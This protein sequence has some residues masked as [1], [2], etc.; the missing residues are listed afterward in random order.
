MK[1][2][3][4]VSYTRVY[5]FAK[6]ATKEIVQNR[7]ANVHQITELL[8]NYLKKMAL[9]AYIEGYNTSLEETRSKLS[10][11]NHNIGNLMDI[12]AKHNDDKP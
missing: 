2:E 9:E 10:E 3:N 12:I 1:I 4:S 5:K 6:D 8:E 7:N 11:V